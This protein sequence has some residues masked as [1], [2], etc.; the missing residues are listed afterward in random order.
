[1][2]NFFPVE[3]VRPNVDCISKSCRKMC[4]KW[5]GKWE[6]NVWISPAERARNEEPIDHGENEWGICMGTDDD[7]SN[8]E[9]D[10]N[11]NDIDNDEQNVENKVTE[12]VDVVAAP[13]TSTTTS[14]TVPEDDT[15]LEDL[16]GELSGL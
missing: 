2:N 13:S 1:M 5:Q 3:I 9:N 6:P 14:T 11:D 8:D 12:E 10:N 15:S 4:T 16:M 7:D